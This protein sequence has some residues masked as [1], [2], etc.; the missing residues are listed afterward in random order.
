MAVPG[1]QDHLLAEFTH[2]QREQIIKE[3]Y[4][5]LKQSVTQYIYQ[6]IKSEKIG[7]VNAVEIASD[8]NLDVTQIP[9]VPDTP[10]D[11]QPVKSSF[12]NFSMKKNEPPKE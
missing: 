6:Q 5:F 10:K 12:G 3:L 8:L 2:D 1:M 4:P 7:H 11:Q 9:A